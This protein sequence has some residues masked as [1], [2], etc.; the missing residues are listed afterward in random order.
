MYRCDP[1]LGSDGDLHSIDETTRISAEAGLSLYELC[2]S[3]DARATLEVGMAYG[4][5]TLYFLAAGCTHT[6]IDPF[7]LTR[8]HGIALANA[9]KLGVPLEFIAESSFNALAQLAASNRK[10]DVILIDGN[11][12]FDDV[13]VDFTLSALLCDIGSVI[14]LDDLWMPSISL[15]REFIR[16]NRK[17]FLELTSHQRFALFQKLQEDGRSW[18]HFSDFIPPQGSRRLLKK[19]AANLSR[20]VFPR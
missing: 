2:K 16:E 6:A 4:F 17:D 10:F 7:E 8:W 1:Q 15:V 3:R 9:R 14:L 20:K 18:D 11:H 13:L 5:S 12:R 19:L